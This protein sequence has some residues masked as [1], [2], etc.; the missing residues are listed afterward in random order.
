[1]KKRLLIC[2]KTRIIL[3]K[4][5]LSQLILWLLFAGVSFAHDGYSQ[6]VLSKRISI[7][8]DVQPMKKVMNEIEKS[9]DVRFLYNS[10][11]IKADKLVS[12]NMDNSTLGDV[13]KNLLTPFQLDFKVIGKQIVLKKIE[14]KI[15][16]I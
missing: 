4:V 12:I 2:K 1:M 7:K 8:A 14:V 16:L 13:L 9:A 15:G 11:L 5:T 3:L 6:D 10:N